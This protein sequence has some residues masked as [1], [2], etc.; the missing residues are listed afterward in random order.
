MVS[1]LIRYWQTLMGI[2]HLKILFPKI[3][4]LLFH[5]MLTVILLF[6]SILHVNCIH[7]KRN[8]MFLLCLT[9]VWLLRA[10]SRGWCS[11]GCVWYLV[12]QTPS[13]CSP[14]TRLE[15]LT[16]PKGQEKKSRSTICTLK[17]SWGYPTNSNNQKLMEF[18]KL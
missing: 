9:S 18:W 12:Y 1:W 17:Y 3:H 14:L 13:S 2:T 4:S 10:G 6:F 11:W 8:A 7:Q 5:S 15:E 16:A